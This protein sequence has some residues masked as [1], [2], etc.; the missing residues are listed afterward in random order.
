MCRLLVGC[1]S[2]GWWQPGRL[3][4]VLSITR[5]CLNKVAGR[6]R[7][8]TKT[9]WIVFKLAHASSDPLTW[10]QISLLYAV[11]GGYKSHLEVH[12]AHGCYTQSV[13][14]C[15]CSGPAEPL[16]HWSAPGPWLASGEGGGAL[17]RIWILFLY[18]HPQFRFIHN[19]LHIV[20]LTI[21]SP[22]FISKIPL[23]NKIKFILFLI[24]DL[25]Y[26]LME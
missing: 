9:S 2:Q 20:A 18:M 13:M 12:F 25:S 7:A 3:F 8:Q 21:H 26:P 11:F 5:I 16:A 1:K 19:M 24:S 22:Y 6:K 15:T 10:T 4:T 23:G 14:W 17:I